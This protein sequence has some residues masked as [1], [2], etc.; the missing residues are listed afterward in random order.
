MGLVTKF[1]Q[2]ANVSIVHPNFIHLY[3]AAWADMAVSKVQRNLTELI[4]KNHLSARLGFHVMAHG[5]KPFE[6]LSFSDGDGRERWYLQ[7]VYN[8]ADQRLDIKLVD[9]RGLEAP[10]NIIEKPV[11]RT[12]ILTSFILGTPT[13]V[14]TD[15]M[16]ELVLENLDKAYKKSFKTAPLIEDSEFTPKQG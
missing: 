15:E 14:I 12:S 10:S 4:R 16:A 6:K 11:A 5:D 7:P 3:G 1:L 2:S 8:A 9:Y 13:N